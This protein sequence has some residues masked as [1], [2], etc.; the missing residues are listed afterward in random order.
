MSKLLEQFKPAYIL[1]AFDREREGELGLITNSWLKSFRDSPATTKMSDTVF[2]GNYETIIKE[3]LATKKVL[4]MAD[5]NESKDK[6]K[7]QTIY[8]YIAYEYLDNVPVIHFI[9]V[10]HTFRGRGLMNDMFKTVVKYYPDPADKS[11]SINE[12]F[13]YTFQTFNADKIVR[14]NFTMGIYNPFLAYEVLF[15][16][17]KEESKE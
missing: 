2:F 3:I 5:E 16:K 12:P 10:K 1:R 11:K 15:N 9:Y 13:I 14:T 8:G 4:V 17:R 7:P 6:T